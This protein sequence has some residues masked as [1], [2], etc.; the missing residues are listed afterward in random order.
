MLVAKKIQA[1]LDNV[2]N[3]GWG[4]LDLKNCGLVEIP[5]EIFEYENLVNI[6]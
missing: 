1:A 2:R 3:H 6:D 5:N 4:I